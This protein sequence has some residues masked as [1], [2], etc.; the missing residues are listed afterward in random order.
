[1]TAARDDPRDRRRDPERPRDR[2]RPAWHA[3]SPPRGSRSSR[4]SRR[5]PG[6][7]EQ[8]PERLLAVDRRGVPA[9]CWRRRSVA[10]DAIAGVTLTTQRG[11]VV[12]TDDDGEPL[13][14]AIVWLD[15]RR[16]AG[17]AG[18]R[19]GDGPRVP[20]DSA[21]AR[22]SRRSPPTARPTGSAR[23]SRSPGAATRHYVVALG[24]PRPSAD[25]AVGG[26][27]RRAG[28]LRPVRL[29]A[30]PL[31]PTAATG[32]GGRAAR[33]GLAAGARAAD[34]APR[35]SSSATRGGARG[36]PAGTPVVASAADK[37]CEVLGSGAVDAV[38][39]LGLSYGTAATINTTQRRYVEPMPLVPPYPAAI[40]GAWY[41]EIQVYRGFWM[42][43]WFKRE[44]G[45][46]EVA[47][48]RPA[49]WPPRRCS[50]S[51]S[52]PTPAGSDGP[53]APAD[54]SPGVRDP[55]PR[56]QGRDRRLRRRPH[57]RPP[58]PRRSWRVSRTPCVRA[59]ERTAARA[60]RAAD[61]SPG[62]GRRR[63][64]PGGRPAHGGRVRAAGRAAPTR[65]RRRRWAR[66]STRPWGSG[67][68]GTW[69]RPRRRWSGPPRP[70]TRIRR[71]R[72]CYDD[73]FRTVYRPMYGR[74]EPLYLE[75]RRI[76]RADA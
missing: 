75:L 32:D 53:D 52:A 45:E 39:S 13:R 2:V 74:L 68:I 49:A 6:W 61:A 20:G 28:G 26:L 35:A 46:R 48:R 29:Q 10:K 11:T 31:G 19:R 57:P 54:W 69:R 40:P 4:T 44:F 36:L 9:R 42:V 64:E 34:G 30:L 55:G 72:A 3:R 22:P 62:L 59:R 70:A 73:L 27:R 21:C 15:Q 56:G 16:A 25:R 23:P 63:P 8:D 43:E 33:S 50:T 18:D 66:R 14:P 7:A 60:K 17:S 38:R 65:T 67:S 37:A 71:P 12:V 5:S 1:M 41:L 58:L 51:S 47:G 76:V 24:V